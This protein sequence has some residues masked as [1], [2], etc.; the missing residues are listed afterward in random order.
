M[1]L[2]DLTFPAYAQML[3]A[4]AGQLAKAKEERGEAAAALMEARLAPDMFAL[5]NQVQFACF[6]AQ[7]L[8][9][10]LTGGPLPQLPPLPTFDEAPA[11]LSATA[12][13]LRDPALA[14][15]PVDGASPVELALPTGMTFD[16]TL[17]EYVRSWA[18]PQ[19]YF[20]IVTAYAI[21]RKEGVALGKADYVPHMFAFLRETPQPA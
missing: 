10:R 14:A 20:H 5:S 3:T 21:L 12:A 19:F 15:H 18:I 16:L 9:A 11:L 2:A 6:Q 13:Q 7:E 17:A 1:T 8:V 4:L